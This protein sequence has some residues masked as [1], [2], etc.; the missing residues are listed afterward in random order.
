MAL[1]LL[2]EL[3]LL[4]EGFFEFEG[5]FVFDRTVAVALGTGVAVAV[6]GAHIRAS[7]V[8]PSPLA[9]PIVFASVAARLRPRR[10]TNGRVKK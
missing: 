5:R 7:A 1:A 3:E 2:G 6:P 8:T 4:L 9:T 10:I